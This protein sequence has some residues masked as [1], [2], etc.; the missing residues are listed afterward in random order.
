MNTK[1]F[2]S[3]VPR[4]HFPTWIP[5][6]AIKVVNY[7]DV[8]HQHDFISHTSVEWI[9]YPICRTAG[10]GNVI[11]DFVDVR[12]LAMWMQRNGTDPM[13]GGQINL[14]DYKVVI[15]QNLPAIHN[16]MYNH[17]ATYH[18]LELLKR[19]ETFITRGLEGVR[20][21]IPGNMVPYR[22]NYVRFRDR[23]ARETFSA[24][25]VHWIRDYWKNHPYNNLIDLIMPNA[26][27]IDITDHDPNTRVDDLVTFR[28]NMIRNLVIDPGNR[29]VQ[30]YWR[31]HPRNNENIEDIRLNALLA[32]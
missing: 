15:W 18:E 27:Y 3:S 10:M 4:Y 1:R 5:R 32:R 20:V 11:G 12:N 8:Q 6:D 17:L 31:I 23:M 30:K 9:Q 26:A 22:D 19:G 28:Y 16:R 25:P 2:M 21:E 7:N 13:T 24:N 14:N 29:L